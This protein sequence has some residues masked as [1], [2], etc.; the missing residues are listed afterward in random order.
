[1]LEYRQSW[2]W[3]D[4]DQKTFDFD[5]ETESYSILNPDLTNVFENRYQTQVA[6]VGYNYRVGKLMLMARARVQRAELQAI[7]VNSLVDQSYPTFYN[8]LPMAMM[9]YQFSRQENLR[10]FYRSNTTSPTISQLQNVI[11]NSNPLQL[12]IG[13]PELDQST[14]HR[15]FARYQKTRHFHKNHISY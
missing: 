6:G 12:A 4:A 1:M 2:Q 13:N 5:T 9:R 14:S 7:D 3:E 11:D 8:V 15:L 10:V